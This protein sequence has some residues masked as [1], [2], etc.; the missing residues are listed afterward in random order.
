MLYII[1]LYKDAAKVVYF[2]ELSKF[3]VIFLIQFTPP[4]IVDNQYVIKIY[5]FE[6]CFWNVIDLFHYYFSKIIS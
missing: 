2:F 1:R 4:L 5:F 3:F 6:I